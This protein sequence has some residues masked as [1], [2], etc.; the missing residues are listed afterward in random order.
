MRA[1]AIL[2]VCVWVT[3]WCAHEKEKKKVASV[4][5]NPFPIKTSVALGCTQYTHI[6]SQFCSRRPE[7][8]PISKFSNNSEYFSSLLPLLFL[9]LQ[10]GRK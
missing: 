8:G 9:R 7:S 5:G 2:R 4:D 10:E 3:P 6:K 1:C